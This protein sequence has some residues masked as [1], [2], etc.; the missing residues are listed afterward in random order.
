MARVEYRGVAPSARHF[1]A[2]G[3]WRWSGRDYAWVGG[4]WE[5]NRPGYVYVGPIW[6]RHHAARYQ[7][8]PG[9][10]VRRY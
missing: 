1:W 10:W 7:Y 6:H 8:I 3:Y 5:Y 4:R 9:H 2:P